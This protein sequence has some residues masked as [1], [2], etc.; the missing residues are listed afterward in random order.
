MS[1]VGAETS[2]HV[3]AA[4][5]LLMKVRARASTHRHL[6]LVSEPSQFGIAPASWPPARNLRKQA[7]VGGAFKVVQKQ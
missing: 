4:T 1:S 5:E 7:G 6:S 3:S 2:Q